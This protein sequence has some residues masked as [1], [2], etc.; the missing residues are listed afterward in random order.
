MIFLFKRNMHSLR[1]CATSLKVATVISAL[2]SLSVHAAPSDLTSNNPAKIASD[3]LPEDCKIDRDV[4]IIGGGS[5][6]IYTA[7]RMGDE[8]KSV[9]VVESQNRLGGH[10]ETYHDPATGTTYDIAVKFWLDNDLVRNYFARYN[11]PLTSVSFSN[12]TGRPARRPVDF[13]TG[14]TLTDYVQPNPAD[15][16]RNYIGQ[17]L[18]YPYL[19]NGYNL[20]DPVPEDLL[21]PFGDFVAK[22]SLGDVVQTVFTIGQGLGDLLKQPTLYV[23]KLIGIQ[24]LLGAQNGYV[25]TADDNN[26][27]LYEKAGAALGASNVFLESTVASICRPANG[28]DD[29]TLV[30]IN[31]PS[32][33]KVIRA[34]K[35]VVAIP[36]QIDNL[37]GFD[38]DETESSLFS[39]FSGNG[40]Y[41][42]IVSNVNLP[43]N[44]NF[45]NTGADT[46]YNL[47]PLPG[48]Y[49]VQPTNIPGAYLA[50]YGSQGILPDEQVKADI[51]ATITRLEQQQA[52]NSTAP[53]STGDKEFLIFKAHVP[54]LLE[55]PSTE[56]QSGFYARLNS[57]QGYR[58]TYYNGAAFQSH[59]SALI[60]Q[61]TE[62]LLPEIVE[63]I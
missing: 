20:P 44:V 52:D 32:G 49:S 28:T 8:G 62:S 26:S 58:N 37:K 27:Q 23:A 34:K 55:V 61:Y 30:L 39:K 40:Y 21:S 9:A 59:N 5:G 43:S 11:I 17:L 14:M 50:L 38:L 31:T 25:A 1:A 19:D 3:T 46:L 33:Q 42:S 35:L 24:V 29:P 47:P 63:G 18:K 6:G 57:L 36:Q 45:F 51:L 16:T 41:T 54:F 53:T 22:Y 4:C 2:A 15:A 13:R 48:L 56:I 12:T 60:W 7:V 10:T